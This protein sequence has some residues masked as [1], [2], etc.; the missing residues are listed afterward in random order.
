MA[1]FI[2]VDGSTNSFA[3]GL[4]EGNQLL[5]YGK[6]EFHGSNSLEKACDASLKIHQLIQVLDVD[7]MVIESAI[8]ANSASVAIALGIAQGATI[9]ACKI[10]GVR[11]IY[12]IA[13]ITWQSYIGNRN[14]TK[15]EKLLIRK[16]HPGRTQSW[17][18][19]FERSLRKQKTIDFVNGT[20]RTSLTDNDVC[21]A[22]GLGH[23]AHSTLFGLRPPI[24]KVKDAPVK[25]SAKVLKKNLRK[26]V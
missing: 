9:G 25:R 2:S 5:E 8:F 6:I 16:D 12:S 24:K 7:T 21:D 10:G 3:F 23:Y 11:K 18:K 14:F 4:W 1:R 26:T 13:P 15:G 22:I 17:Y 19:S 20:Y